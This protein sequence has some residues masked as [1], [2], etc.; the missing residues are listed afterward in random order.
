M[1]TQFNLIIVSLTSLSP[2]LYCLYDSLPLWTPRLKP[3]LTVIFNSVILLMIALILPHWLGLVSPSS[4]ALAAASSMYRKVC[5]L[6]DQ[7]CLKPSSCCG[8]TALNYASGR[9][10]ARPAQ[11][12]PRDSLHRCAACTTFCVEVQALSPKQ[13]PS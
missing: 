5:Q 2:L 10:N 13:I 3:A 1:T 8:L 7:Q 6:L 4:A 12:C 11:G 9:E